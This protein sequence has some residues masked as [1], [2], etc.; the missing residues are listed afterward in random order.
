[1][2]SRPIREQ[3]KILIKHLLELIHGDKHFKLPQTVSDLD[4]GGM[5]SIRLVLNPQAR[6]LHDLIQVKYLDDDNLLVLIT[7]ME[8]NTNELFEL[9]FWKIYSNKLVNYPTPEKV[10]NP[11][12]KKIKLLS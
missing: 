4:D 3:E 10:K 6:Y 11:I 8:S 12:Q 5:Q 1:M 2:Q 9:E 7:L